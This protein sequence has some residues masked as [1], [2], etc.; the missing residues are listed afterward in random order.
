MQLS[1][2]M[3]EK[4]NDQIN[5]EL[6]SAY[7]YLAMAAVFE[8]MTLRVF[9]KYYYKQA[10]EERDH[11]MRIFKYLVDTGTKVVLKPIEDPNGKWDSVEKIVQA[12]LDHER[13]VT[14]IINGL[15][16]LAEQEKDYATRSFLQW[17][18]DEQ[19]EE[20]SSFEELLALVKMAGAAILPLELRVAQMLG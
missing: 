10:D 20:E 2:K 19:V 7:I 11:A 14:G 8:S 9:A 17:F 15:V 5:Y 3:A 13:E 18:V 4:L 1:K 16:A 12:T 6:H